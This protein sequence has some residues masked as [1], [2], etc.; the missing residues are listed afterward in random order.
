MA[1]QRRCPSLAGALEADQEQRAS[2]GG[3]AEHAPRHAEPLQGGDLGLVGV[4]LVC[5]LARRVE[6]GNRLGDRPRRRFARRHGDVDLDGNA[7]DAGA[8]SVGTQRIGV[9][10]V[11]VGATPDALAQRFETRVK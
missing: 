6:L 5:A 3:I 9:G 1:S 2:A 8:S 11:D 10:G 4:L 7:G